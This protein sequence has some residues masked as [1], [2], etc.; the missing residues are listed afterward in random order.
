MGVMKRG[1]NNLPACC[2]TNLCL[3]HLSSRCNVDL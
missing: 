3:W 2:N 1:C